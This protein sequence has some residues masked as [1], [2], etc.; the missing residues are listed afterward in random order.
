MEIG[1]QTVRG[2]FA[3][4]L[5]SYEQAVQSCDLFFLFMKRTNCLAHALKGNIPSF[6]IS[7]LTP[8]LTLP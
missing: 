7:N 6:T 8:K 5:N 2:Y 4:H 1:L 3:R